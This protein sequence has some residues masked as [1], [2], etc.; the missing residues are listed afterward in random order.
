MHTSLP[1]LHSAA[2]EGELAAVESLLAAGT[3]VNAREPGDHTYAMH[4]A[5][6]A[7][8]LDVVRTLADAGGDVI[9]SGDDHQLG[10]IG[11]ATCWDQCQDAVAEFL[12]GRGARHHIF[13]AI[14]MNAGDDVRRLVTAEPG[15]LN[16]RMSRN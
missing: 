12:L 16:R 8:E 2:R 14:A 10:V 5:A 7:G 15:A 3:D 4:W 6:A 9:G 13:S 11:W 1:P